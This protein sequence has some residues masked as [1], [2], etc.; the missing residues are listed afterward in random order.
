MWRYIILFSLAFIAY[1][2]FIKPIISPKRRETDKKNS[3]KE[4]MKFDYGAQKEEGKYE[5]AE[6]IDFEEIKNH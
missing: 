4:G 6:D 2:L 5:D 1:Q 3:K